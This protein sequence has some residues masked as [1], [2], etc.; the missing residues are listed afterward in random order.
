MTTITIAPIAVKNSITKEAYD[1]IFSTD[2]NNAR[3]ILQTKHHPTV[4]FITN[5]I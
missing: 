3:L 2:S 1:A 4:K 5:L